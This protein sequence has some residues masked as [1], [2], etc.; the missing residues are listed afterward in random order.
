[1]LRWS[2]GYGFR[3][4]RSLILAV[5]LVIGL[6]AFFQAAWRAGDMAPDAAP[7]LISADWVA[8][9][10]SHPENPAAFWSQP[11][12][13]GQ[14][15]ETFNGFAYAADL[16]V[17]LVSLGQEAAW[18]PSTSRSPLGRAGW[19]MRW[20]AKALGWV[21]AALVAAAV[22]GVIRRVRGGDHLIL[23]APTVL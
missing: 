1:V 9:T 14:D 10:Q 7:I 4:E 16:V 22:T 12:Q 5:L 18:A 8:A 20:F 13:A 23:T 21:I 3:P 19:W 11:G 17:P 15:Y 6:G 2:V